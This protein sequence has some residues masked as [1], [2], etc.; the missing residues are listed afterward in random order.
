M[1]MF[2]NKIFCSCCSVP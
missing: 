2:E 1:N